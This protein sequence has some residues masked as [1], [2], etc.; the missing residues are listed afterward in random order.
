MGSWTQWLRQPQRV[1][2]RRAAFQVHLWVGLGIGLY[3]VVL[4][5]TGSLLVYRNELDRYLATPHAAFDE[6]AR[7]MNAEE[8]R[9]VAQRAY[10]DWQI[11][12]VTEGRTVRRPPR[13]GG[14]GAPGGARFGRGRGNRLPDPTALITVERNGEKKERLFNPYTGQDL[15]DST[16]KAQFFI[17]WTVRL[18]D[19]LLMDRPDGPWWNGLLSLIFTLL[20]ITGLVVWWPGVTRWRRSLGVKWNAGWRRINW[21]LHSALGFWLFLFMLMWGISGWYLGMPEPLTNVVERFS[22][23]EGVYGE[24]P[25]DIALTW[26]SRLHFGRW[27]EPGWGP[28]LKALW[29]VAGVVPAIM[30]VTGG[31]MWWNRKIRHRVA[32]NA[33][34]AE[35]V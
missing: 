18:H 32:R 33:P 5:L 12:D 2:L 20:I 8:L 21:D 17:L 1:W 25:G 9:E 24:R 16:T 26:L 34:E 6:N 19:E 7:A 29:A 13:Q 30:F 31:V 10:P 28:W 22:D 15:G 35:G 23:P 3:V 14:P 11:T 27:R 4:S